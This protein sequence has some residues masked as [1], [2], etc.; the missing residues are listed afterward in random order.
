MIEP[1]YISKLRELE[2]A[3][4]DRI[5]LS[6][7]FSFAHSLPPSLSFSIRSYTIATP[8]SV[9]RLRRNFDRASKKRTIYK[10]F[11]QHFGNE[12]LRM[13]VSHREIDNMVSKGLR[14]RDRFGN[15]LDFTVDHIKSLGL[16]GNNDLSNFCMLPGKYNHFKDVLERLQIGYEQKPGQTGAYMTIVPTWYGSRRN[17]VP[18]FEGGYQPRIK[19]A[20]LK[21]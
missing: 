11:G 12:L 21:L 1:E 9:K 10:F 8:L 15:P 19:N 16:G 2:R 7:F 20:G 6:G 13:G 17:R 5:G 14:P 3:H 18:Y 4:K